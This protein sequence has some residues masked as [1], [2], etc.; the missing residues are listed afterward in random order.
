MK[1]TKRMLSGS[2]HS[3]R[4]GKRQQSQPS[5][6]RS[7]VAT[8]D[9]L[10]YFAPR[11]RVSASLHPDHTSNHDEL[12]NVSNSVQGDSSGTTV[13]RQL[14]DLLDI[15][16]EI[17]DVAD[18]PSNIDNLPVRAD[19]PDARWREPPSSPHY[20]HSLCQNPSSQP[21]PDNNSEATFE[22]ELKSE[23]ESESICSEE[24]CHRNDNLDPTRTNSLEIPRAESISGIV[25]YFI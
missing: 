16:S 14:H 18:E 10:N 9:I 20:N 4:I 12:D 5:S 15:E 6:S 1:K 17:T 3:S 7:S 25:I 2:H 13:S 8:S 22:P 19:I 21:S 23:S 24:I 11:V